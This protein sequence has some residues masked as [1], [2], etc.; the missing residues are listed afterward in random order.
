MNLFDKEVICL[1]EAKSLGIVTGVIVSKKTF[2]LKYLILDRIEPVNYVKA[3]GIV[4]VGD[5]ILIKNDLYLSPLTDS[6][7]KNCHLL[8]PTYGVN[9]DGERIGRLEKTNFDGGILI[10]LD[11]GLTIAANR[12]LTASRDYIVL[13]GNKEVKIA[14]P[15]PKK[16]ATND[17]RTVNIFDSL[18]QKGE[19]Q[20]DLNPQSFDGGISENLS[21]Q[22]LQGGFENALEN[23]PLRII[24]DYHFLLGRIVKENVFSFSGELIIAS[25]T[26]VTPAVVEK[27]R[28][29]GKLIELTTSSES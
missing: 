10:D 18:T 9:T 11:F 15:L 24:S 23:S 21:P 13:Q 3:D 14:K 27:A 28:R 17:N 7:K 19:S 22:E 16:I 8:F 20:Q 4:S 29:Y 26:T 1:F 2:K 12:I 6:D 25:G 5:C